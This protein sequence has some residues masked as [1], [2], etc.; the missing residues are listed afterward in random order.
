MVAFTDE[1]I[2][3]AAA[4]PDPAAIPRPPAGAALP[5]AGN[6]LLPDDELQ[7]SYGTDLSDEE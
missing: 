3:Q 6:E 7:A 5:G 4:Q 2:S 1:S